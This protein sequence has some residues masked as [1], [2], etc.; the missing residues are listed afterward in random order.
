MAKVVVEVSQTAMVTAF[1]KTNLPVDKFAGFEEGY[2]MGTQHLAEER[3]AADNGY[4]IVPDIEV[5][6]V[7]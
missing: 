1:R 6:V 5:R 4:A 3:L 2:K 7:V